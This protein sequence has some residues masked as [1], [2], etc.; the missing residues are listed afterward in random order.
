MTHGDGSFVLLPPLIYVKID[1]KRRWLLCQEEQE[2]K[3]AQEYI[4]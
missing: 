2:R 3:V 1:I 4:M